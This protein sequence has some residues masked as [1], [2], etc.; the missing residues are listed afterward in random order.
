MMNGARP[1]FTEY[2]DGL[3]VAIQDLLDWA[4]QQGGWEAPCWER[5]A[6]AVRYRCRGCGREENACSG[7]PCPDVIA[8]RRA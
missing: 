8:D 3:E 2:V 6:V 7:D 1:N 5:A 4:E